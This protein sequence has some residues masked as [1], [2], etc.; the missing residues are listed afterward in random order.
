LEELKIGVFASGKGSNFTAI[1]NAIEKGRLKANIRLLISNNPESG[2]LKT[3][4]EKNIP[5]L[6]IQR[7]QFQDRNDFINQ[8]IS[9]LKQHQV[10]FIALAGY[11]KKI[12][13]EVIEAYRY[14]IVNIHPALLPSFGGKG[15]YG[16]HVHEAVLA[17][18]CKV[19][20]VT[21]H[22]V[23]DK[24]DHGPIVAQRCVPVLEGD[25]PDTLAARV[26]KVEHQLYSE[27]LQLFTE[28]RVEVKANQVVIHNPLST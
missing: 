16:H 17:Q 22:I 19:S 3:A 20:G 12:P 25:T 8:L 5:R 1:L 13:P 15:M 9:V 4:Q 7:S 28:G 27:A 10:N 14:R 11:M 23:D 2:A 21:I 18:G 6:I 24:Y 26:L